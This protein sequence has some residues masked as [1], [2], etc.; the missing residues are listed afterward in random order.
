DAVDGSGGRCRVQGGEHQ[1]PRL[2]GSQCQ[3]DGFRIAQFA[4]Q[5]RI[6]VL[7]QSGSQGCIEIGGIARDITLVDQTQVGGVNE[8]YGIFEGQD[9]ASLGFILVSD[10]CCQGS[11]FAAAGGAGDQHQPVRCA[12]N[13]L[14]NGRCAQIIQ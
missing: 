7:S 10:Q 5:N 11:G 2:G 12:S 4:D 13:I 14:A 9:V 6:R 8:R 3:P 1:M